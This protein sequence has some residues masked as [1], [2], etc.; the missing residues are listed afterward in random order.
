MYS[1]AEDLLSGK[2]PASEKEFKLIQMEDEYKGGILLQKD[3]P[4]RKTMTGKVISKSLKRIRL[5]IHML[6]GF[7]GF[8]EVVV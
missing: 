8:I 4:T 7:E 6:N 5:L 1:E 2:L 3:N